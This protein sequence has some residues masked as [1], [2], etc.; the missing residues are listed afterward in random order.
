MQQYAKRHPKQAAV[1]STGSEPKANRLAPEPNRF[2]QIT[3]LH[4]RKLLVCH[5]LVRMLLR[6]NCEMDYF[7]GNSRTR[8]R[9]IK[10][11][12]QQHLMTLAMEAVDQADQAVEQAD[13]V[14][15]QAVQPVDQVV[16]AVDQEMQAVDPEV[17]VE[18]YME[19]NADEAVNLQ[20]DFDLDVD[21]LYMCSDCDE[22]PACDFTE[23][24][25]H[26]DAKRKLAEW[27]ANCQVSHSA[28]SELLAILLE[29]G[30]DVPKDPRTLLGTVKNCEVKEMGQGSYYHFRLA[31]AILSELK[32]TNEHDLTT[33]TL[34]ICVNVDGLPLSRSSNIQL[35]PILGQIVELPKAKVFIIGV[36][37]GPCKPE[38]VNNYIHDFIEDLKAI[39][40][41]GVMLSGKQY[42]IALPDPFICDTPAR[43][44][45]KCIKGHGGYS[46]CERCT[47]Y[48]IY[49]DSR[50]VFPDMDSS[51]RMSF[52]SG[53]LL[54]MNNSVVEFVD[55][56]DPGG[57][58]KVDI[59]QSEWFQG[60][61]RK[62]C[63][64]PPAT[65]LNVTK[66]VKEGTPPAQ[67]WIL[68][69]MSVM[70]NAATYAEARVKLHQAEYTSDLTDTED[71]LIKRK[72]RAKL[73]SQSK[74]LE[75]SEDSDTED[76]IPPT[77]PEKLLKLAANKMT[78]RITSPTAQLVASSKVQQVASP[79][80]QRVASCTV[81]QFARTI[82]HRV[83][84]PSCEAM[85]FKFLT[86]VEEIKETQ[87][88]HGKM[89]NVLKKEDASV[90]EVPDG[91]VFP[92][93]TQAGSRGETRGAQSN[94]CCCIGG[95]SVDDAT[96]R[97]MKYVL[98]NQLALDY[99]M[100]GRHEKKKFKDL[101][102]FNV[103]YGK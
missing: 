47:Q 4:C 8:R 53:F 51:L 35:W 28:L 54:L 11:R 91:V 14:V 21:E 59:I 95:T 44:F 93:Q 33:D 62:L 42:N 40:T 80:A 66:A 50:V 19:N 41:T 81:Q 30:L 88:V 5:L 86:I 38:S 29:L 37:A 68:C 7:H 13:Q 17:H 39:T 65:L 23:E 32:M 48:G 71:G 97:M 56:I 72:A 1:L 78:S 76:E 43:A 74:Q 6:T 73:Q 77:P 9:R 15:D 26:S 52:S 85:F 61:D 46:S 89:L 67:N 20:L 70:G 79:T 99:N 103:V 12:V 24:E 58:K 34:T 27:A 83:G 2:V 87:K 60:A 22:D 92:L 18:E 49:V 94:V 90:M 25:P 96:R 102:L 57:Y 31:S 55:E 69:N 101:R 75:S 45:L 16:Q 36:Y 10:A 82:A 63:W 100:F 3:V 64:W 84:S 98:S